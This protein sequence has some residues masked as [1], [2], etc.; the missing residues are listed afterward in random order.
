MRCGVARTY[1]NTATL[2]ISR[3]GNAGH[4]DYRGLTYSH[5]TAVTAHPT[6]RTL[7]ARNV[8]RQVPAEA[9]QLPDFDPFPWEGMAGS[10]VTD[11]L[12]LP[13]RP[14]YGSH[15]ATAAALDNASGGSFFT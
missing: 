5:V 12:D 10:P 15:P 6:T 3:P 14:L 7:L 4:A 8:L 9:A 11:S 2:D 13:G 1:L